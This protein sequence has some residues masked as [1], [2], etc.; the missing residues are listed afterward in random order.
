MRDKE[1]A[2]LNL[3]RIKKKRLPDWVTSKIYDLIG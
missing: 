3:D 1:C 2:S